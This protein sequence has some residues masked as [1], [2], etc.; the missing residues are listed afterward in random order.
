MHTVT[1][2]QQGVSHTEPDPKITKIN[3]KIS[4][5]LNASVIHL[6]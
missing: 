5:S 3:W 4:I 2:I 6:K 1:E